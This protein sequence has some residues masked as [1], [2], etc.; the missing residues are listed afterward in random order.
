MLL[1]YKEVFMRSINKISFGEVILSEKLRRAMK[2]SQEN[3]DELY[4]FKKAKPDCYIDLRCTKTGKFYLQAVETWEDAGINNAITER[5]PLKDRQ[6]PY[7]SDLL[8]I[9]DKFQHSVE[10]RNMKFFN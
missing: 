6:I 4:H 1:R 5:L 10:K 8:K 3:P 7:V 9:Y 2:E